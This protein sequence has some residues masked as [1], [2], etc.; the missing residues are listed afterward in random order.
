MPLT[1]EEKRARYRVYRRTYY[2]KHRLEILAKARTPEG[3]AKTR[4]SA[5]K[6]RIK[7]PSAFRN[8]KRR[9]H[10]AEA[11]RPRP[12]HCEICGD[13]TQKIH[14]DHCHQRGVFRGWICNNCNH[15]L[16]CVNDD[17][18]R[19]RKLIAYLERTKGIVSPQ[20]TLPV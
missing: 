16:G 8:Y 11:G 9:L 2:L 5:Q 4:K 6:H 17:P 18:D 12:D 13:T 15:A 14:F 10:E 20:L 1:I 19:L 3:R 7:W